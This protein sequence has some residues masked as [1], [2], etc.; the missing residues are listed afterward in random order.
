MNINYAGCAVNNHDA[1]DPDCEPVDS[2]GDA[3]L[4]VN[5]GLGNFEVA[6]DTAIAANNGS[7]LTS[8]TLRRTG[9]TTPTRT[10][11]AVRAGT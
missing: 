1:A 3:S 9:T 6:A 8:C 7:T 5:G 10:F 11:T 2:C 4:V